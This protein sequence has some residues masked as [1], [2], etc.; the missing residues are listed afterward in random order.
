M[1]NDFDYLEFDDQFESDDFLPIEENTKAQKAAKKDIEK[2]ITQDP[3]EE[4]E[5]Q[6]EDKFAEGWITITDDDDDDFDDE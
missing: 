4:A 1:F 5:P 6:D 3:D 2:V